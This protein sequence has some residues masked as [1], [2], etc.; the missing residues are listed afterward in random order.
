MLL[1]FG[2]LQFGI[3]FV[4]NFRRLCGCVC[5]ARVSV[6]RESIARKTLKLEMRYDEHAFP[7]VEMDC[8]ASLLSIMQL[9]KQTEA[10]RY[11]A[12]GILH[13]VVSTGWLLGERL[14]QSM[15]LSLIV[16]EPP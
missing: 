16:R 8:T 12:D 11:L 5:V 7:E 13:M 9:S 2:P 6:A 1:W 3:S 10:V 14:L 4:R 15:W